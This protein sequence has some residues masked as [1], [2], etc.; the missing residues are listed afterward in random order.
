MLSQGVAMVEVQRAD[1]TRIPYRDETEDD[2][3]GLPAFEFD[4]G[5]VTTDLLAQPKKIKLKTPPKKGDLLK[6]S[7]QKE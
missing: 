1:E 5:K 7:K 6:K 4:F 2:E 3:T